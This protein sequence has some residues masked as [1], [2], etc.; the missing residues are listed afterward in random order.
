MQEMYGDI[1]DIMTVIPRQ[2]ATKMNTANYKYTVQ[3]EAHAKAA[4]DQLSYETV[5]YGPLTHCLEYNLRF[6]YQVFGLFDSYVQW[7]NKSRNLKLIDD[8]KKAA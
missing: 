6:K 5:T 7:C 3:P 4:I 2:C 1:I 8:Y